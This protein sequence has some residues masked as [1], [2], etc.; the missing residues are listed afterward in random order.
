MPIF[1]FICTE[2]GQH[3]EEL[4]RSSTSADEVIC[5][6]CASSQVKKQLSTFATRV[7]GGSLSTRFASAPASSCSTG[8]T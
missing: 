6:F 2:C 4:V 7:S 3:F 5:P 8:S 1:E